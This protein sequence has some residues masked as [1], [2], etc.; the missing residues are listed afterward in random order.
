M[1]PVT[2]HVIHGCDI[3]TVTSLLSII[4]VNITIAAMKHHDQSYLGRKGFIRLIFP[5]H[6][7]V[8]EEV[9]T[10]TQRQELM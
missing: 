6:C 9:R 5:H 8:T 1:S 4:L 7:P 10:G 3:P 2:T